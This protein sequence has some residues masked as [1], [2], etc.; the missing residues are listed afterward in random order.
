MDNNHHHHHNSG[1]DDDLNDLLSLKK[2]KLWE[3]DEAIGQSGGCGGDGGGDG[4]S[5]D[6]DETMEMSTNESEQLSKE[7]L[8]DLLRTYIAAKRS[9][10]REQKESEET[11]MLTSIKSVLRGSRRLHSNQTSTED[12]NGDEDENEDGLDQ[13]GGGDGDA[14]DE[15]PDNLIVT[16]LPNDLFGN[17]ELKQ[18][19]EAMF[20]RIES[21]CR[22][23]YFRLFKRC[24]IQF[25]DPIAAILARFELDEIV[26]LN[27]QLKLYLNKVKSQ[28]K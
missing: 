11:Q 20:T 18:Q 21:L 9:N 15:L 27:T 7:Q 3:E 24:C 28:Q 25:N 10:H 5:Q 12:E 16:G 8:V 6:I 22:F 1:N 23:S 13:E 17:G 19:F 14:G 26:F 2:I 4:M